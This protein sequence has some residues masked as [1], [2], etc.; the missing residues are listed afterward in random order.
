[1]IKLS[2]EEVFF[3]TLFAMGL[4]VLAGLI[5]LVKRA[6]LMKLCKERASGEIIDISIKNMIIP[7]MKEHRLKVR[8]HTGSNV[9]EGLDAWGVKPEVFDVGQKVHV[10]Y[11]LKRPN[12]LWVE[13]NGSAE[14]ALRIIRFMFVILLMMAG[15]IA[16]VRRYLGG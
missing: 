9:V 6:I 2:G 5:V 4:M 14:Y 11:N 1:M 10:R 3:I 8:F 16:F 15:L 12:I 13:E 7:G